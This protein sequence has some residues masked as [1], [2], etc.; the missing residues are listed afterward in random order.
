MV[1]PRVRATERGNFNLVYDSQG[2]P[3]KSGAPSEG[4]WAVQERKGESLFYD[5]KG[6]TW[7]EGPLRS[8]LK[9]PL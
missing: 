2:I 5:T 6:A 9:P 3:K 1:R 4:R 8:A 7:G